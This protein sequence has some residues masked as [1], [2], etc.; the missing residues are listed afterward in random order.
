[1][2]LQLSCRC[3]RVHLDIWLFKIDL[4]TLH[5]DIRGNLSSDWSLIYSLLL[6]RSAGVLLIQSFFNNTQQETEE[7]Y[8]KTGGD[9]V[10]A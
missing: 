2:P 8:E 1:M 10:G 4:F 7:I 3:C 5:T 6:Y 9:S